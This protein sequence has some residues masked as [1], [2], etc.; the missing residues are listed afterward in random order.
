MVEYNLEA[1]FTGK[2]RDIEAQRIAWSPDGS[3]L[4][5]LAPV[6]RYA[7]LLSVPEFHDAGIIRDL[8]GGAGRVGFA[9]DGRVLIPSHHSPSS[10]LSLWDPRDNS[11]AQIPGP[12]A[13]S[14]D[15]NTNL[16]SD[17][18]LDAARTRL[19]GVHQVR[20]GRLHLAIYDAETWRLLA[21][22]DLGGTA[23]AMRPNGRQIALSGAQGDIILAETST[24]SVLRRIA[25]SQNLVRQLAWSPDGKLL[26]AGIEAEGFGLNP[27]TGA[28][29]PLQDRDIIQLWDADSGQRVAALPP[30][31]GALTYSLAFHPDGQSLATATS[32]GTL[33]LWDVRTLQQRQ[34]IE[35]SVRPATTLIAFSPDGGRLATVLP[36]SGQ[37]RLYR[38]R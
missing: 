18:A 12:D 36:G 31:L 13:G 32:D 14:G 6:L 16:L 3:S 1:E 2:S 37:V 23:P 34:L 7:R 24:G 29:G 35:A 15:T 22:R 10:A 5:V 28:F 33:R 9:R 11:V 20:A 8:A 27:Q 25:N 4:A 30:P 19:A 21:D 38:T 26:A 17:F